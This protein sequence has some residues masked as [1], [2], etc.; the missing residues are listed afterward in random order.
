MGVELTTTRGG[1]FV[2]LQPLHQSI[3]SAE[4]KKNTI[5]AASQDEEL[6]SWEPSVSPPVLCSPFAAESQAPR[7]LEPCFTLSH[8]TASLLFTHRT[9]LRSQ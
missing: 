6:S 7:H 1:S 8:A 2:L 3:D 5:I 4:D 9:R